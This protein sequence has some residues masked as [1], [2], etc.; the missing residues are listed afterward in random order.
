[1]NRADCSYCDRPAVLRRLTFTLALSRAARSSIAR[2]RGPVAA[3]EAGPARRSAARPT[4]PGASG[5]GG[6]GRGLDS[7]TGRAGA[8]G[9][10]IAAGTGAGSAATSG[11]TSASTGASTRCGGA[12]TSRAD[13]PVRFGLAPLHTQHPQCQA[14]WP[15]AGT[16]ARH[17]VR[18]QARC[19]VGAGPRTVYNSNVWA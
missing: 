7:V 18:G 6:V 14:R 11:I 12:G 17:D 16:R 8:V 3:V 2:T 1:V 13:H 19:P 9:G 15:P 10:V 4:E 5:A